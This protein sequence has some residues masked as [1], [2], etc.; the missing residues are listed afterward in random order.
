MKHHAHVNI[1][2]FIEADLASTRHYR[3]E[4]PNH[5]ESMA[6]YSLRL[7]ARRKKQRKAINDPLITPSLETKTQSL[8]ITQAYGKSK[9]SHTKATS[10]HPHRQH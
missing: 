10:E 5:T 9:N 8:E 2:K 7:Y 1:R 3:G 4:H 6:G